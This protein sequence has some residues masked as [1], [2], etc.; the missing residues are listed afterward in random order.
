[1]PRSEESLRV[2]AETSLIDKRSGEVVPCLERTAVD[3][4]DLV[5]TQLVV[6]ALAHEPLH[7]EQVQVPL[8]AVVPQLT[9]L[10]TGVGLPAVAVT[11][12]PPIGTSATDTADGQKWANIALGELVGCDIDLGLDHIIHAAVSVVVASMLGGN[13]QL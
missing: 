12:T 3:T 5:V 13:R 10:Q 11:V 9:N 6:L 8:V 4:G 7:T 1:M 2:R